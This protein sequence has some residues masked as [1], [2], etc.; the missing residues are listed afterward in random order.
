MISTHLCTRRKKISRG[1]EDIRILHVIGDSKYGGGSIIIRRLA[2]AARDQGWDVEVLTTDPTFRRVLLD[3]GIGVIHL[4]AIWRDIRPLRDTAGF[5][6]LYRFLLQRRY[7]VVHTHTSKAGFLGR[8]AAWLARIPVT[9]HTVHG[10]AFHE[11]SH[12]FALQGYALLERLAAHWCDRIVTVSEFHRSW[13]L[14]LRIANE[15]KILAIPNG[16]PE[17]RVISRRS[18]AE[19]RSS[20]GI[21]ADEL[22]ILT[23]GRL[24]P[25]KGLE[26]LLRAI[27]ILSSRA[28]RPFR[29]LLAGEG[30]MRL[31]LESLARE[32]GIS[33]FV[34]F[35]GFRDDIGDL[36]NA[37]DIVVLP[38]L[39]EG[40]SIALLEA[41]AAGKPI[42][43]TT[44]GTN[45]EVVQDGVSG[46]LVP[47]KQPYALA[48][49]IM[50]LFE[51][52][53]FRGRLGV[54][55]RLRYEEGYTEERMIQG[56]MQLYAE[57]WESKH[58]VRQSEK[59]NTTHPT[60]WRN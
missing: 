21:G 20:L 17:D 37:S 2:E 27:P 56:Y 16:I 8:L 59:V 7:G 38:S 22:V 28:E 4:E 60:V 49:A 39:R 48:E 54:G 1:G 53:E 13:A 31:S 46:L 19:V 41:M 3:T 45:L 52:P 33:D 44:I 58:N 43:T 14:G 30:P 29:V 40:L 25:Q 36:L 26:Y 24:A 15:D 12:F 57:L 5:F 6:R 18:A 42:V 51:S 32:L 55:A 34:A 35:L 50:H 47:P 23:T 10:F 11:Q 9:I